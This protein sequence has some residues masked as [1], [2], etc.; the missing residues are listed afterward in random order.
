MRG[1]ASRSRFRYKA[2]SFYF[3]PPLRLARLKSANH[4]HFAGL[5]F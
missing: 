2:G 5:M 3:N 4:H 1:S